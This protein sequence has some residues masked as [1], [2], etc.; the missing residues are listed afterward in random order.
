VEEVIQMRL[1][2]RRRDEQELRQEGAV[3]AGVLSGRVGIMRNFYKN[4]IELFESADKLH[5]L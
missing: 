1:E 2:D 4:V 3:V 5:V